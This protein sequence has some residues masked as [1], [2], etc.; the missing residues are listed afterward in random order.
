[1][2]ASHKHKQG[3]NSLK[4]LKEKKKVLKSK[5][6]SKTVEQF[7]TTNIRKSKAQNKLEKNAEI[8][9]FLVFF[10]MLLSGKKTGKDS[11]LG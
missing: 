6:G 3:N 4:S 10:L 5:T 11:H 1:M 7:H 9:K 2:V 8:H